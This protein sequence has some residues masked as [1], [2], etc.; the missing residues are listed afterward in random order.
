MT[1]PSARC[2]ELVPAGWTDPVKG[3]SVPENAPVVL[4][5]PLTAAVV[6]A[7]VAP[8][9]AGFV[10]QAGQLEKANGR[11]AD[12]ITIVSRCEAMLNATR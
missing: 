2:S 10:A 7:I 1:G 3:A 4:G 5:M 12:S 9:Q 6:A 11:T 8:W